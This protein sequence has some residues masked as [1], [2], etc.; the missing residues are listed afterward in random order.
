[1]SDD[2]ATLDRMIEKLKRLGGDAMAERVAELAAPLVE[3][4]A[5]KTAAAGTTPMGDPWKPKK[6]G[7]QP[8]VH[9]AS[10]LAAAARGRI[11][12][13]VLT[14]VDVFHHKGL[15]GKPRRQIIPDAA[16]IPPAIWA[17]VRRACQRAWDEIVR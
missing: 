11:V 7:G 15:G 2:W 14:G 9:A 13:L 1:M 10:H 16:T 3:A 12:D 5:K 17:A 6:G 8:L 4:E